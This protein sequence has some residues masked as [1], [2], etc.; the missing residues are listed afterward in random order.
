MTA[1]EMALSKEIT[2]LKEELL[3]IELQLSET[4]RVDANDKWR[5]RARHAHALKRRRLIELKARLRDIDHARRE[6]YRR[7][8]EGYDPL[9]N[10]DV[11]I[12]AA[13]L[14]QSQNVAMI[15]AGI[16][17]TDKAKVI[18]HDLNAAITR[19]AEARHDPSVR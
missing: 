12:A 17:M 18:I 4:P 9:S 11:L 5:S 1:T 10:D 13:E 6:E 8:R 16:E 19:I 3:D 2:Q 7:V 15:S 14:I